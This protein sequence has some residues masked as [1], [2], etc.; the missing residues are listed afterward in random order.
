[1]KS[2]LPLSIAGSLILALITGATAFLTGVDYVPCNEHGPSFETRE[3]FLEEDLPSDSQVFTNT[4]KVTNY[5]TGEK[6]KV[7]IT[8][9]IC[10]GVEIPPA[11]LKKGSQ[12]RIT[13]IP[14]TTLVTGVA[15]IGNVSLP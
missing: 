15:H 6:E 3:F 2:L 5:W 14:G 10:P 1:M 8:Y 11:A 4:E 9:H 7:E 13:I 12:I